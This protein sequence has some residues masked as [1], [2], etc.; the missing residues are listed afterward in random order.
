LRPKK[1]LL[2][3]R[4]LFLIFAVEESAPELIDLAG[5]SSA[6]SVCSPGLNSP[7]PLSSAARFSIELIAVSELFCHRVARR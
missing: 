3:A 6:A 5:E 7:A 4:A 1:D 2:R